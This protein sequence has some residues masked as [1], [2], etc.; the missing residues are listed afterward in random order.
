MG[1]G[2]L[3][4]GLE[5]L[6]LGWP[7]AGAGDH[8]LKAAPFLLGLIGEAAQAVLVD[9]LVLQEQMRELMIG[10]G[11]WH[12]V[13]LLSL[14]F[15]PSDLILGSAIDFGVSFRENWPRRRR[16]L[17]LKGHSPT[18]RNADL[19]EL[20]TRLK[21]GQSSV[22]E[23]MQKLKNWPTSNL[24]FARVDHHRNLRCGS[25]EVIFA[26]GKSS[27][28]VVAI[29]EEI[30]NSGVNLLVTRAGPEHLEALL[31][32]FPE[33]EIHSRAGLAWK[34]QQPEQSL[35]QVALLSAGTSDAIVAEEARVT[36]ELMGARVRTAYDV[37]VAGLH[38]LLEVL[39]E[40]HESRVFVVVAG[41]DGALPSVV[42][43]LVDRPVI[44]VPTSV[45]YGASLGGLAALLT[46]LNSCGSGVTVVN[47]DN[48][49]G[50]GYAAAL[51]NRLGQA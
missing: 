6:L 49:F 37:G 50:A 16:P 8:F 5:W 31:E 47:I 18:V 10:L 34:R 25:P 27:Q 26:A 29:A 22:A 40:L 13:A 20:L 36:A 39:P 21:G 38:R 15:G 28:E 35:G 30:L 41:M 51:M 45:G 9:Q 42:A 44:A 4:V 17:G 7:E 1:W 12:K 43:G 32:R 19:K 33:L 2:G 11:Q 14:R 3:I 24:D 23:V 46:M 48:G